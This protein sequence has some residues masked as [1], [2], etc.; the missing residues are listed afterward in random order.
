MFQNWKMATG[1]A[2]EQLTSEQQSGT[3]VYI[4]DQIERK[5]GRAAS[6]GSVR[7]KQQL[8]VF[9]EHCVSFKNILV[10]Q[11]DKF[12]F[13]RSQPGVD[14]VAGVMEN[15]GGNGD[16]GN[17]VRLSLWPALVKHDGTAPYVIIDPEL[18]WTGD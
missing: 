5:L 2:L 14:F 11:P 18:V 1:A 3:L 15:F 7:R 16:N 12:S 9:L 17:S 10:R 8:R 13:I 4:I 6:T